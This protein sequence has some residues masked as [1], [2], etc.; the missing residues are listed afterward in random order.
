V[1]IGLGGGRRSV[2]RTVIRNAQVYCP[3][4]SSLLLLLFIGFMQGIYIYAPETT[5]LEYVVVV[6][7][8]KT[9]YINTSPAHVKFFAVIPKV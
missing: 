4:T 1:V 8:V 3:M 6:V 7:V 5:F 9:Y 2:R